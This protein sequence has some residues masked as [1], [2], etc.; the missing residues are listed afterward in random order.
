MKS[1]LMKGIKIILIVVVLGITILLI[2]VKTALPNVGEPSDLKIKS[3]PEMVK[4][5]EYLA[6]HVMVCMDCH[7]TRDWS[8]FSGPIS[9]DNLGCGG[10]LFDQ[11]FGFPG[12]YYSRNVT[13]FNLGKWTDGEIF[14]TITCGVTKDNRALFP[15]MPYKYY[16]QLDEEDIHAVI[17]YLR[18]LPSIENKIPDSEPDFPFNFIIN[19]IPSKGESHKR[20]SPDDVVAYGKYMITASGCIE[21]HTKQEKGKMI[22]EHFAGGFEFNLG[23]GMVVRSPNITPHSTGLGNWT[24]EAFVR[25][26]KQYTDSGYV[27]PSVNMAKGEFQTVM[28]WTMYAGMETRDLEAIFEYLQTVKPVESTIVRFEAVAKK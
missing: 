15:I 9:G 5:G 27:L 22:G 16:G 11:K 3:T 21:C 2:Y 28:P 23:N 10:E 7:S 18:T 8:K 17:A 4:R 13:P 12:K 24:K 20:P 26:F 1:K 25:R 14:R 19:T 6:N